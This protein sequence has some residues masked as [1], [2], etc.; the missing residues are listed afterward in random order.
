MNHKVRRIIGMH[1][2][3][4]LGKIK[5]GYSKSSINQYESYAINKNVGKFGIHVILRR[6]FDL[7]LNLD[8]LGLASRNA[9]EKL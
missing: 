2:Y 8:T 6:A 5:K 3:D 7:G 9:W 1:E 4:L